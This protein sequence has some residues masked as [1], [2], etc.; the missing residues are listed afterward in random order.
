MCAPIKEGQ[1]IALM[2]LTDVWNYPK[3]TQAP[4]YE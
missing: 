3:M 4:G 1:T 2:P